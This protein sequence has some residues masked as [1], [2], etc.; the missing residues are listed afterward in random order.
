[1]EG[2]GPSIPT[3]FFYFTLRFFTIY[4]IHETKQ[5]SVALRVGK[6]I[7]FTYIYIYVYIIRGEGTKVRCWFVSIRSAVKSV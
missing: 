2:L 6:Q 3:L 1:M 4:I 7:E 5:R